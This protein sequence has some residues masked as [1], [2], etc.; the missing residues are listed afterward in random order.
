MV[1]LVLSGRCGMMARVP[2]ARG[3]RELQAG[4]SRV[5]FGLVEAGGLPAISLV[6]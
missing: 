5:V 3:S 2:T 4:V 1:G 6:W